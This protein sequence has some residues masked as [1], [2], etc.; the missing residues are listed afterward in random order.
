MLLPA[1]VGLGFFFFL[2]LLLPFPSLSLSL[3]NE[4]FLPFLGFGSVVRFRKK[5]DALRAHVGGV[6]SD[7]PPTP[8]SL[9]DC[10]VT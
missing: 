2:L 7:A 5:Q 4:A 3:G 1:A 6:V 10:F 9:E 8:P